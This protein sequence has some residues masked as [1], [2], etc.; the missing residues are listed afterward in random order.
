M[1]RVAVLVDTS[2]GWGRRMIKGVGNYALKNDWQLTVEQRGV[3]EHLMIKEGWQGDGVIARVSDENLAEQIRELNLPAINVSVIQLQGMSF[4]SIYTDEYALAE[5][6]VEHFTQRGFQHLAYMSVG[7]EPYMQARGQNLQ[8]IAEEQG[9]TCQVFG[10]KLSSKSSW[11]AQR[12]EI[13]LWLAQLPKPVGILAWDAMAGRSILNVCQ[14]DGISVPQEVSVLSS[15]DDPLL[16]EVCYPPMS[17][18]VTSAE[19]IGYRAAEM[20]DTLLAGEELTPQTTFPPESVNTRLSTDT[21]AI[22]DRVLREAIR[23]IRSHIREPFQVGD[24]AAAVKVSRRSLERKFE[25]VLGTSPAQE[26]QH[27]RLEYAKKL[28]RDTDMKVTDVAAMSG[29]CSNEY[30]IRVFQKVIGKTPLA[31]R[32]WI[33]GK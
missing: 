6:A 9:L 26:I 3:H 10:R 29:Y 15:D 2:T 28:I 12:R 21:I 17:G 30:M 4:P 7:Q 11:E 33:R 18:V 32:R 14:Q 20:L 13:S 8:R 16:S 31:Y 19:Q 23:Y 5:M 24:V 25:Q 27:Y 1:K 22:D